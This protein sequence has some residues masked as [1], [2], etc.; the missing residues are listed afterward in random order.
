MYSI[1]ISIFTISIFCFFAILIYRFFI[2]ALAYLIFPEGINPPM[3]FK[4]WY[5]FIMMTLIVIIVDLWTINNPL[6]YDLF[7]GIFV[8]AIILKDTDE[9]IKL[10]KRSNQSTPCEETSPIEQTKTVGV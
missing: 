7:S 5:S 3:F 9:L 8:Y 10:K 2:Q 4:S 1:S 6:I